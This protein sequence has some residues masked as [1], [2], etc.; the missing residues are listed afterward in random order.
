MADQGIRAGASQPGVAGELSSE[1][2]LRRLV[3]WAPNL[4]ER[5]QLIIDAEVLDFAP[6]QLERLDVALTRFIDGYPHR[7]SADPVDR[8]A[9]GAAIRKYFATMGVDEVFLYASRLLE[10]RPDIPVPLEIELEVTKM[11][12][13]RLMAN[14][15]KG[16][17]A[18]PD[19]ADRLLE[20]TRTYLNPRLLLR[21]SYGAITLNAILGLILLGSRHIAEVRRL[22]AELDVI[23][24]KQSVARRVKR[25]HRELNE[26]HPAGSIDGMMGRLH[27]VESQLI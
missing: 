24:F 5:R 1:E 26:M 15:S 21:E 25:V 2:I 4:E 3:T 27:E 9:V 10:A 20:L 12:V 18:F 17:D 8:V 7:G 11:V 13:R 22:L 14:P 19:L 23:W 16:E 6:H